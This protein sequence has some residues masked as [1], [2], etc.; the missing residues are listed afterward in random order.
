MTTFQPRPE[1]VGTSHGEFAY[2]DSV[3]QRAC[4]RPTRARQRAAYRCRL[5][6]VL[7]FSTHA[8]ARFHSSTLPDFGVEDVPQRRENVA[9]TVD[10][11]V[12]SSDVVSL[13]PSQ[14]VS[15]P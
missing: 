4:S 11:M 7:G 5:W 14:L 12:F 9:L 1:K 2:A 8:R 15:V 3:G 10:V 6:P 13:L